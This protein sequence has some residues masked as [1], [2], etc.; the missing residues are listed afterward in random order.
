MRPSRWFV[1][2]F[3]SEQDRMTFFWLNLGKMHMLV[4]KLGTLVQIYDRPLH[5]AS[6]KHS[7]SLIVPGTNNGWRWRYR[8]E[9]S[10]NNK[11]KKHLV[12]CRKSIFNAKFVRRR[13]IEVWTGHATSRKQ[14][15]YFTIKNAR[16]LHLSRAA[17]PPRIKM[18]WASPPRV[19][20]AKCFNV[21][22][23]I[24]SRF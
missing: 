18:F 13:T 8:E 15:C 3:Y 7:A 23:N 20:S 19:T 14:Q 2:K 4:S 6:V 1:T 16:H 9:C 12:E 5:T 11:K 17:D 21:W 10:L 22:M 24:Y